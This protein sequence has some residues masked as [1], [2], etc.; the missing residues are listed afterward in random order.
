MSALGSEADV[1]R[2]FGLVRF[3]PTG[4]ISCWLRQR[5]MLDMLAGGLRA[6]YTGE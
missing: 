5:V 2:A 4:A 1:K 3:V 6:A